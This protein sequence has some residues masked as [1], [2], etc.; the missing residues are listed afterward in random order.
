MIFQHATIMLLGVDL[1]IVRQISR[2]KVS[3]TGG[4][5]RREYLKMALRIVPAKISCFHD[6]DYGY[7]LKTEKKNPKNN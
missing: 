2:R 6:H 4:R 1:C 7:Y 3:T 5:R